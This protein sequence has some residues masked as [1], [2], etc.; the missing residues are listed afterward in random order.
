MVVELGRIKSTLKR[1]SLPTVF[2][3]FK[4]VT[5]LNS[6]YREREKKYI[7]VFEVGQRVK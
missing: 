7:F 1:S 5:Y 3:G 4:L 2:I 6:I